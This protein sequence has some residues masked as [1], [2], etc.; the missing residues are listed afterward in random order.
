MNTWG[1]VSS[2]ENNSE[3][4]NGPIACPTTSPCTMGHVAVD[5]HMT[6]TTHARIPRKQKTAA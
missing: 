4:P 6:N 5:P 2:G 3:G 1:R